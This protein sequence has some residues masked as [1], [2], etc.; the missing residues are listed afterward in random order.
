M[1]LLLDEQW[2]FHPQAIDVNPG[3]PTKYYKQDSNGQ[4]HSKH[5]EEEPCE[6]VSI[7]EMLNKYIYS[8]KRRQ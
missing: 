1:Y 2:Q 3:R 7:W 4:L 6:N 8:Y 5:Y